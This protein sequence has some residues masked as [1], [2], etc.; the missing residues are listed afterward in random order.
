MSSYS[1]SAYDA[2][3]L[4]D[5]WSAAAHGYDDIFV[6]Q[7]APWTHSSLDALASRLARAE[8][9]VDGDVWVPCCGPGQELPL[10][11][12]LLT[13][14]CPHTTKQELPLLSLQTRALQTR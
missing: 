8:R 14:M 9:L 13:S 12:A 2:A 5:S 1:S 11:H 4:A 6:R 7:F 3:L 10:L